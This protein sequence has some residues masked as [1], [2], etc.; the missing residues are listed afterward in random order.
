MAKPAA[1]GAPAA[2]RQRHIPAQRHLPYRGL[3]PEAL[4]A[5]TCQS[6]ER[7][8]NFVRISARME[9]H[10][11]DVAWACLAEPGR[12]WSHALLVDC[13]VDV[14]RINALPGAMD[15]FDRAFGVSITGL[16]RD[17]RRAPIFRRTRRFAPYCAEL[18]SRQWA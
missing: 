13:G 9:S 5:S 16:F 8:L 14:G 6:T 12:Y 4:E 15:L 7:E 10:Y 11:D 3:P 1:R 2:C 18:H 17:S